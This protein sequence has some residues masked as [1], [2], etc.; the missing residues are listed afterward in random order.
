MGVREGEGGGGGRRVRIRWRHVCWHEK[1]IDV[2][3]EVT[4]GR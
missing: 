2:S 1:E 4:E 3:N